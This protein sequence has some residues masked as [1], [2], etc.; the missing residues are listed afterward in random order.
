MA[1]DQ[2]LLEE[3]EAAE[4]APE[5]GSPLMKIIGIVVGLA[6]LGGGGWYAYTNFIKAPPAAVDGAAPAEQPLE[7]GQEG[8]T[9]AV[10][11]EAPT[12]GVMYP[13]DP[14]IVNLAGSGGKRFLKVTISMELSAPEVHSEIKENVQK[15]TDSILV[16]LSSKTF[17]DVY[18]VQGKFRLKDEITTRVNRF[19]VLGHIKDAYFTE[20]IIQ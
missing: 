12:L 10:V 6:V 19:L 3:L 11:E 4:A 8:E 20:F 7:E 16:L 18:S 2:D 14:F 17:E 13:L 1:E 15:I 5:K 9:P